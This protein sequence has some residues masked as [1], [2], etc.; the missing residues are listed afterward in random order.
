MIFSECL[1]D[2]GG[3]LVLAPLKKL[4]F[5]AISC[6]FWVLSGFPICSLDIRGLS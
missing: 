4:T 6:S 5:S 3:L 2:H 1:S